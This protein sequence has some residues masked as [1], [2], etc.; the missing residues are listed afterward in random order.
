VGQE[1]YALPLGDVLEIVSLSIV[2][3]KM[4]DRQEVIS[5]RDE[6]LSLVRLNRFFH[7]D[8]ADRGYA[9]IVQA[10]NARYALAVDS[11]VGRQ[12]VVLKD[13]SG[14]LKQ[15]RGVGGAT[16]LGDGRAILILDVQ[17]FL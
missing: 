10:H 12:E 14:F 1:T 8:S 4:V 9:L 5:L 3:P 17:G 13:V 11:L 7:V 6:V 2:S 15:I 16:I